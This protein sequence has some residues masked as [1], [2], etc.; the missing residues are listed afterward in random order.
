MLPKKLTPAE[1]SYLYS[2]VNRNN[3]R[4]NNNDN[5][6]IGWMKLLGSVFSTVANVVNTKRTNAANERM[7]AAQNAMQVAENEKAYERSKATNQVNLLQQAGMSKAGALSTIN[8]GGS[9]Q[10][11]PINVSQAQAPEIDLSSAFD[12]L[13]QIGENA[14]QRKAAEDLQT[15]Q[16][17]AAEDAQRKQIESDER[18]HA[19]QLQTQKEIAQLQADTTNRNADNRLQY[20]REYFNQVLIPESRERINEIKENTEYTK[21]QRRHFE[22]LRPILKENAQ[23]EVNRLKEDIKSISSLRNLEVRKFALEKVK[24][25]IESYFGVGIHELRNT[26]AYWE[27]NP[28]TLYKGFGWRKK[29]FTELVSKEDELFEYINEL[30]EILD[31]IDKLEAN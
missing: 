8:G 2:V 24:V 3:Y 12:G 30:N 16:I 29:A 21:V 14:K 19:A 10:P 18:K 28:E 5:D 13:I 7:T 4:T 27:D 1:R 6:M 25:H 31:A 9:Y 11:A 15:A 17:K 22:D 26:L 20:D 23:E